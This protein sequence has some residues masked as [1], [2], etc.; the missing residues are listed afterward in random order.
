MD[1]YE[2]S[3]LVAFNYFGAGTN[4]GAAGM[5]SSVAPP[6][7]CGSFGPGPEFLTGGT[8][9]DARVGIAG[10]GA[11]STGPAD[12]VEFNVLGSGAGAF[13]L[14]SL[15]GGSGGIAGIGTAAGGGGLNVGG[16]DAG[17]TGAGA[18]TGGAAGAGAG[19]GGMTGAVANAG[20]GGATTSGVGECAGTGA[21]AGIVIA[22]GGTVG[23][24]AA[25]ADIT[26]AGCV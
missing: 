9:Y 1:L 21:E 13:R 3:N 6:G 7:G 26:G 11:G 25:G 20:V 18:A 24:Y 17:V 15:G 23:T 16:T 2:T 4:T 5:S 19:V 10:S 14:V 22:C 12:A 8:G